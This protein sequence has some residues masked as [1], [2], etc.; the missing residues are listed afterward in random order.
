M[1][2]RILICLAV[3]TALLCPVLAACNGGDAGETTPA[4][5]DTVVTTP[6]ETPIE[7]PTEE[8]TEAPAEETTE[9]PTE[10]PTEAVT[11]PETEAPPALMTV[12]DLSAREGIDL[13]DYFTRSSKCAVTMVEDEAEGS[14]ARL[15]S[16]GIT[17]VGTAMPEKPA[18]CCSPLQRST[19]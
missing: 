2:K 1:K 10:A 16:E 6:T 15:A 11:E 3:L 7:A 13:T 19:A 9:M 12:V 5:T 17:T 8:A 18:G 14:I 4:P